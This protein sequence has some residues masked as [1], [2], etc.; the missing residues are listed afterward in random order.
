ME[1]AVSSF[2]GLRMVNVL[3]FVGVDAATLRAWLVG[4][5]SGLHPGLSIGS[6][7]A[8]RSGRNLRG[9]TRCSG[10]PHAVMRCGAVRCAP[11]LRDA[12]GPSVLTATVDGEV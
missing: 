8:R 6:F 4:G 5:Q 7:T 12:A 2:R 3:P 9:A 10:R 11:D 1:L